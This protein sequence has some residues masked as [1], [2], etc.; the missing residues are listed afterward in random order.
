MLDE[1]RSELSFHPKVR[2]I[3]LQADGSSEKQVSQVKELAKED[4]DLLI[5]SPNEAEPLTAV[6]EE[7]FNQGTP[8]IVVDRKISSPSFTAFVGGDDLRNRFDW[9]TIT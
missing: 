7:V 1:M 2:F 8:V 9:N 4:I 6:V 5:I 3:Y